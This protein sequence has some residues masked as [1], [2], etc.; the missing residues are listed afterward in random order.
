MTKKI[1]FQYIEIIMTQKFTKHSI[2]L[3]TVRTQWERP[4]LYSKLPFI[5]PNQ[6]SRDTFMNVCIYNI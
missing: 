6:N 2:C 1:P 5:Q 4:S 3:A